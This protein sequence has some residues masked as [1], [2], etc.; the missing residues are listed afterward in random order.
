MRGWLTLG[1][2]GGI[3]VR[4]HWTTPLGL[5]L[6]TGFSVAP[7]LWATLLFLFFVHEM[8]HAAVVRARGL[9]VVEVRLHGLGGECAHEGHATARDCALIAWGGPV[10]QALLL[11]AAVGVR[12]LV[13]TANP[14]TLAIL[15]VLT[16]TNALVLVLNLLP[17][18]PLDGAQAWRLFDP[19]PLVRALTRP[20]RSNEAA[21]FRA[22]LRQAKAA[23]DSPRYGRDQRS[24]RV[25]H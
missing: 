24:E 7:V 10:A 11:A 22:R 5:L 4:V 17:I 15:D 23:K 18:A 6:L 20:R 21:S 9:R 12:R 16:T 14:A 2:A 25:W 13:P 3:P 19:R 8:G 1:S